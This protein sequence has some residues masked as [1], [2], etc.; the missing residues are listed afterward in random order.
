MKA[1]KKLGIWMDHS[2]AQLIDPN[3]KSN[4]RSIKSE[5]SFEVREEALKRNENLMHNKEQQF[6][7]SYYQEIAN[8]IL[9]YDKVVLFGP[10]DAKTELFNRLK[11]DIH[12]KDIK[13]DLEVADKMS[14]NEKFAFVTH[15]FE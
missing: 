10:T 13:I 12:Y 9:S 2:C 14:D 15:H 8:E 7:D 5:F 11:G 6:Q 1:E 3:D 4:S